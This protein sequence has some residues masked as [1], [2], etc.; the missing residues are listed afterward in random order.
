MSCL[1]S[2]ILGQA[3]VDLMNEGRGRV[4]PSETRPGDTPAR[5][6]KMTLKDLSRTKKFSFDN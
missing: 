5:V 6:A 1:D 3:V 2:K 4:A